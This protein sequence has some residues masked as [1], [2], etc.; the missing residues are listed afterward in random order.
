MGSFKNAF[1][2]VR[3]LWPFLKELI[4][5]GKSL[6]E[7]FKTAKIRVAFLLF[8]VAGVTIGIGM[9]GIVATKATINVVSSPTSNKVFKELEGRII[10]LESGSKVGDIK[11]SHLPEEFTKQTIELVGQPPE[12]DPVPVPKPVVKV[13]PKPKPVPTPAIPVEDRTNDRKK[14][15]MDFFDEHSG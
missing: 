10:E 11:N 4:L 9:L 7:G 5:E 1:F 2:V 13:V 14:D 15:Y 12:P 3:W 8:I 6:K